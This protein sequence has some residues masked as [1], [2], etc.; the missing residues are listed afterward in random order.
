M[1]THENFMLFSKWVSI[2]PNKIIDKFKNIYISNI[3]SKEHFY[4]FQSVFEKGELLLNNLLFDLSYISKS[5]YVFDLVIFSDVCDD[6]SNDL[7]EEMKA[8]I[9]SE[10]AEI[11]VICDNK[12][13]NGQSK[14]DFVLK[15][16]E[17]TTLRSS[18]IKFAS[19]FH[20]VIIR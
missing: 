14:K 12:G 10:K 19:E 11:W 1:L 17:S 8:N 4:S 15:H 7:I 20:I 5:S 18:T 16:L 2:M 6:F 3:T 9:L 13:F